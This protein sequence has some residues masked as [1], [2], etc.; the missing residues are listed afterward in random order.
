MIH[1]DGG[2]SKVVWK[3]CKYLPIYTV[4]QSTRQPSS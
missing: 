3:V 1:P 4:L 2:D